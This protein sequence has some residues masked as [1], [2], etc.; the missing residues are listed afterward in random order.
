MKLNI[1]LEEKG[2]TASPTISES[3]K[4]YYPTIHFSEDSPP[5]FPEEG[6]MT[7]KYKKVSST[8]RETDGKKVY[9]CTLEIQELISAEGSD[10]GEDE[11]PT[12][13]YDEAGDA[14][15]KLAAEKSKSKKKKNSD[16]GY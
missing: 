13:S 15:D 10:E 6:E 16:E 1:D 3:K 5:E 2:L 8:T 4:K 14:L 12:K 9:E 7:V 11:S